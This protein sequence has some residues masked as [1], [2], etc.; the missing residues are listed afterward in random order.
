[1]IYNAKNEGP[2]LFRFGPVFFLLILSVAQEGLIA[3]KVFG[4]GRLASGLH[5]Q[6]VCNER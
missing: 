2:T 6:K 1:M 4:A 3:C 5:V